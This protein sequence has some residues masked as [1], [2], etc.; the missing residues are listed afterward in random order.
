MAHDAD[1]HVKHVSAEGLRRLGF[2]RWRR[3]RHLAAQALAL[4]D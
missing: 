3:E 2:G 4:T 1:T